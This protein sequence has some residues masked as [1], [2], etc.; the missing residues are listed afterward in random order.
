[1]ILDS[2]LPVAL[3]Y[4]EVINCTSIKNPDAVRVSKATLDFHPYYIFE[5]ILNAER[6]D[7][8]GKKRFVQAQGKHIVNAF[9]GDIISAVPRMG[10]KKLLSSFSSKIGN[11][12]EENLEAPNNEENNQTIIDLKGIEPI[13][14]YSIENTGD[15]TVGKIDD[16]VSLKEAEKTVLNKI[17]AD[18]VIVQCEL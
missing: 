5:Y 6:K 18:N 10:L 4:E 3:G 14:N 12:N 7:P 8:I 15:Y 17:I 11:N 9:N 2:T 13:H 16:N 1:M